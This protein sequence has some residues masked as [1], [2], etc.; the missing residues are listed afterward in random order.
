MAGGDPS[1]S[2]NLGQRCGVLHLSGVFR[3]KTAQICTPE[4]IQPKYGWSG[5][6]NH[7]CVVSHQHL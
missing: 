5:M 2:A 1:L 4:A 7:A 6:D 3:P